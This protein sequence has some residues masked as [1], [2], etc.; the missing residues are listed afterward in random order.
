M[1]LG[2]C[3]LFLLGVGKSG[4]LWMGLVECDLFSARC[5][6]LGWARPFLGYVRVGEGECH[7]FLAG[8]GG[9]ELVCDLYLPFS[10]TVFFSQTWNVYYK[11]VKNSFITHIKWDVI[12]SSSLRLLLKVWISYRCQNRIE[13]YYQ[14][15]GE[16]LDFGKKV[17]IKIQSKKKSLHCKKRKNCTQE[18]IKCH[19]Q[20]EES[21]LRWIAIEQVTHYFPLMFPERNCGPTF[22][23]PLWK[24]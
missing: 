2:K 4:W 10:V 6:W 11:K 22:S 1:G 20:H 17:H 15:D 14:H 13:K 16:Q 9:C 7:R 12:I 8:C 19:I 5:G 24:K 18:N 3:A 23:K 21:W